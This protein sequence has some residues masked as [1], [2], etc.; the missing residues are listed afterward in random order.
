MIAKED[1]PDDPADW[2]TLVVSLPRLDPDTE[3]SCPCSRSDIL[4]YLVRET[5]ES[6]TDLKD[7][8]RFVRTAQLGDKQCWLWSFVDSYGTAS[9]V[10]YWHDPTDGDALGVAEAHPNQDSQQSLSPEQF[11]LAEFYDL[12]YW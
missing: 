12:V 6:D 8:L 5:A 3:D 9:Y 4:D 7:R 1:L 10:T 2:G 11:I